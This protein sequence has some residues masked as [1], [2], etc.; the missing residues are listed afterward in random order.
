MKSSSC[1]CER[2]FKCVAVDQ[3]RRSTLQQI[4]RT[5]VEDTTRSELHLVGWVPPLQHVCTRS[6]QKK[7]IEYRSSDEMTPTSIYR[8]TCLG[9]ILSLSHLCI[10]L[11][12]AAVVVA[13]SSNS[14]RQQE[15]MLLPLGKRPFL[16]S[17]NRSRA[18][19]FVCVSL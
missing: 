17:F 1:K 19:C 15:A 13:L 7:N 12:F 10:L 14:L 18:F 6:I 3:E 4:L 5:F 11:L 8:N 9:C 16:C 2:P